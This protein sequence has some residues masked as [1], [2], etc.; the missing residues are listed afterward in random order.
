M[1]R[2]LT[3]EEVF[4]S[5]EIE[6]SPILI[7]DIEESDEIQKKLHDNG[8]HFVLDEEPLTVNGKVTDHV[9]FFKDK[10]KMKVREILNI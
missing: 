2:R 3:M 4:L 7:V 8:I 6:K 5:D 9:F 1:Q 10:D